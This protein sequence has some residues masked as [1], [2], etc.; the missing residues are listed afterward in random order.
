MVRENAD[1]NSGARIALDRPRLPSPLA[2]NNWK[3][4]PRYA[5][6]ARQKLWLY[7]ALLIWHRPRQ[8]FAGPPGQPIDDEA[9][10]F[11]NGKI[12]GRK[13]AT[14]TGRR[15]EVDPFAG[16]PT[17]RIGL[18]RKSDLPEAANRPRH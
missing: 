13:P 11:V 12:R 1:A 6:T 10:P 3:P 8:Q 14:E 4:K 9:Y 17:D 2:F 16:T 5:R 15:P 7:G 18:D